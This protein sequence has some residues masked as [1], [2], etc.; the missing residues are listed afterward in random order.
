[1]KVRGSVAAV[2]LIVTAPSG[3]ANALTA[4]LQNPAVVEFPNRKTLVC[5]DRLGT[6]MRKTGS[7]EAVYGT[8]P[9]WRRFRWEGPARQL[10]VRKCTPRRRS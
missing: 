5:Q 4:L 8:A 6:N 2:L 10:Q 3:R 9:S 7:D 1:M